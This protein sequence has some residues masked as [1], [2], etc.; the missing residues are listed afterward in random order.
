M[1]SVFII[2]WYHKIVFVI[3][4][5][6]PFNILDVK[7]IALESLNDNHLI[8]NELEFDLMIEY[9]LLKFLIFRIAKEIKPS[10]NSNNM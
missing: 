10:I 1:Q 2:T 5:L 7:L 6:I 3:A 8:Y 4:G 9:I